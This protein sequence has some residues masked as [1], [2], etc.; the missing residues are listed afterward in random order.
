MT[1]RTCSIPG[2]GEPHSARGWC[3]KHYDSWRT[4]GD[5]MHNTLYV[6]NR[7]SPLQ[8]AS[9]RANIRPVLDRAYLDAPKVCTTPDTAP[10][11]R[12]SF[13]LGPYTIRIG[14]RP[15][16]PAFTKFL[17]YR[18]DKFIGPNFS[19]PSLSD[20]ETLERLQ[21]EQCYARATRWPEFS[22]GRPI[23]NTPTKRRGRPRKDAPRNEPEEVL[24]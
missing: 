19:R 6:T 5:P 2:C 20:C 4:H 8:S 9:A 10:D 18:G 3:D 15:D 17:V 1:N 13:V 24:T 22:E 11:A 7:A 16:N 21:K 12:G 14:L 23:W